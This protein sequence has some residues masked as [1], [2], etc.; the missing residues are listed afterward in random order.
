M[1]SW[2]INGWYEDSK[3]TRIDIINSLNPH[4]VVLC[5]THLK[6]N[7]QICINGYDCFS[8]PRGERHLRAKKN[9]GGVCVLIKKTLNQY[10][11]YY[12]VDKCYDGILVVK[13]DDKMS[14]YNFLVV[15]MYL[16]PEQSVW[17][18]DANG[19]FNHL[20]GIMYQFNECDNIILAGDLNS[21]IGNMEDYIP[22]IDNVQPRSILDHSRNKHGQELINFLL[23]SNMCVCN[24]RITPQFDNYTYVHT[25][26]KS[27]IDYIIVPVDAVKQCIK[28][29]VKTVRD[30]LCTSGDFSNEEVE[31]RN[32]PDH[33]VL[34]LH[35]NVNTCDQSVNAV[36][37]SSYEN[38]NLENQNDEYFRRY[39][40][41]SLPPEFLKN[42]SA[43]AAFSQLIE[44][45]CLLT[46]KNQCEVDR[47]YGNVCNFYHNE[48]KS[49][50]QY[51]NITPNSFKKSKKHAKPFW[52]ND[53]TTLWRTVCEK[54]KRY[55]RAEGIYRAHARHHYL[56]AQKNFH[57][58]YRKA[59]R[60]HQMNVLHELDNLD[61]SNPTEF[62]KKIKSLGPRKKDC[63]PLEVYDEHHNI[64]NNISY[65]KSKWN[66][67]FKELY[68]YKPSANEFDD[69]FLSECV[70]K[71]EN[72]IFE[73]HDDLNC[74]ITLDEVKK[75][76]S[77]SKNGKAVGKDNLPYEI[78]KNNDSDKLL[79]ALF[80]KI[81]EFGLT[82]STWSS[83]IIK[84][85]P[86]NSS[87][88]PR[89]PSEY[90]GI[91]LLSTVYKLF[92]GV[93]NNRLVKF[94]EEN[95][96]YV[97]EQNGFRKK[98]SCEDHLFSITAV[99]RNRKKNRLPTYVAFVD[100]EKAFDRIDHRLLFF[101]LMKMGFGGKILQAIKS[102]YSDGKAQINLNGHLTEPFE[103]SCGVRQGDIL[104]P[105]LFNFF[106]NG[107]SQTLNDS[108]FGVK[109]NE[110]ITI[111]A[112][113]YADDL[114][115][116]AETEHDL[117]Q[118]LLILEHWCKKWRM[119]V[120]TKKTKIVHFR[121]K[122]QAKTDF[123]FIFNNE[124]V[125]CVEK[126][127]YLGI[128]LDEHL[129]FRS[130]ATIL[131]NSATR[132]LGALF[133]KFRKNKGI[134]F[135]T[136]STLFH[137]GIAPILDYASAIWGFQ[138]YS[139]IDSVQNKALRFFLGV[140]RFATTA[141]V[142]GDT[143]WI[144]CNTR[145]KINLLRFWNRMLRCSDD[146][147][148]K[149]IFLWDL[150]NR[151]SSGSW[152]SDVF[153]IFAE[154]NLTHL[155]EN[156]SSVDLGV[157]KSNLHNKWKI[158][159]QNNIKTIS[160]LKNYCN[161]KTDYEAEA[162]VYKIHNRKERSLLSQF[163]CGILPIRIETGRYTQVPPELRLCLLCDGDHIE[164]ESH[165]FFECELYKDYRD[166]F[167]TQMNY[168]YPNFSSLNQVQM[169]KLCMKSDVIRYTAKFINNCF[170]K[171]Q[172]ILYN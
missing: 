21:K 137:S 36:V 88:D 5:E 19:F 168:H 158:S 17:G 49:L 167:F 37:Q 13:F 14:G 53:L 18:R 89:L 110:D 78:F 149:K 153:K 62:W 80:N 147:L 101:Q 81:F 120:N 10:Y 103:V 68:N 59:K 54:E 122:S 134:G 129:D 33:S 171:R 163:R 133:S 69:E 15:A 39:K 166:S 83:A 56:I 3:Q 72:E 151:R 104:S 4:I 87:N 125:E 164:N 64:V 98:R 74:A 47:L 24:G 50:L 146:R 61:K 95:N 27:I 16:S 65:V 67:E 99:I 112:L 115:I 75:V 86:K 116:I 2:N 42:D 169:L 142:I 9:Y 30:L 131:A 136:F 91:S 46:Q 96:I 143:G 145:R 55:L 48:M 82:P 97:D 92:S 31:L 157:A 73:I 29:E 150:H 60:S 90:R 11:D 66:Q 128:Y 23:E 40:V 100:Y 20:L 84:P 7:E 12:V 25:R 79:Q 57:K 121:V 41:D 154:A 172:E 127:K 94:A 26:G 141:A 51:K 165:F 35:L 161:F 52:N 126:Y 119:R 123:G 8:F 28:F 160:K 105:T 77:H 85:I 138:Q 156:V 22:E 1:I 155:Y 71:M 124:V 159:W 139:Q 43:R 108:G 6:N 93:L 107:L 34:V 70:N 140:H 132:A 111:A 38:V 102:I 63:I 144:D 152:S 109:L 58:Q 118:Q 162:F 44:E 106:I 113:L 114:A 76:I 130:T 32:L 170:T 45:S 135:S 148:T 117:Q